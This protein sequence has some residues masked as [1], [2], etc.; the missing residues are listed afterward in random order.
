MACT[1]KSRATARIGVGNAGVGKFEN[2]TKGIGMRSLENMGY[3]G[4]GLGKNEQGIAIPIEAKLRP[5]NMGMGFNYFK[6]TYSGLPYFL[7][8]NEQDEKMKEM[9]PR[10]REKLWSKQS[11]SNK[12]NQYITAKELLAQKKEQE[13]RVEVVQEVLDMRGP[14]VRVLKIIKNLNVEQK[15]IADLTPM[16][17]LQHNVKLIFGMA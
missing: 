6:E 14:Q 8:T 12:K 2:H 3:K 4:G 11:W 7:G 15:A 13:Q 1:R 10:A 9:K 16:P 17:E 5:K